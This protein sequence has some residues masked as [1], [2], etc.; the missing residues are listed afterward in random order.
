MKYL[1]GPIPSRRLG[2]SLGI[3]LL[4][5]KVCSFDCIY[6]EVAVTVNKT[7]ER[8][9]YVPADDVLAELREYL[10]ENFNTLDFITFSGSGEPTLHSRIGYIIQEI[11]KMTDI[12]VCVLTNSTTIN[13]ESV[14]QELLDADLVKFSVDAVSDE[15]VEL[16]DKP[17]PGFKMQNIIN[18]I[19]EFKKEYKGL[20]WLEILLCRGINDTDEEFDRLVK[21][22]EYINPDKV[23]INTVA[24]PSMA[25]S[26]QP[27][28]PERISRLAELIGHK[29]NVIQPFEKR[30]DAVLQ[31]GK[32]HLIE[33]LLQIRACHFEE[34]SRATGLE[35][36]QLTILL[37]ELTDAGKISRSEFNGLTYFKILK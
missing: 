18:G 27:A 35:H 33:N 5:S 14:R 16:I 17:L 9:E 37:T 29:A 13:N 21:M 36:Q 20:V 12:P 30:R 22:V 7:M 32:D 28:A 15:L 24:R 25:Y 31:H 26:V 10:V 11:K 4:K 1:S 2:I 6:C 8:K 34:I 23:H 3:D 19:A